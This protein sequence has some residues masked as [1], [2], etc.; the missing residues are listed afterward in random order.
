[1]N[2][3]RAS[4]LLIATLCMGQANTQ[5]PPK[6]PPSTVYVNPRAGADDP[7]VGLKGGLYDA[8]EAA[9]GM[10]RIISLPKPPGFAPGNDAT[11]GN[12]ADPAAA[13]ADPPPAGA[14]ARTPTAQ[15][16]STNS[17]ESLLSRLTSSRG[18]TP[19]WHSPAPSQVCRRA[20]SLF[21]SAGSMKR[22]SA[23]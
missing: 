22:N 1:M 3:T 12:A 7:R 10:Q 9:S 13:P 20:S 2:V 11:A 16:G 17:P 23:H 21:K 19:R 15:Y 14:P 6:P 8:A 4:I 18:P 5:T